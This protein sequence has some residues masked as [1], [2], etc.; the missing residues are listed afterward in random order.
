MF[1]CADKKKVVRTA[2]YRL[3]VIFVLYFVK[4]KLQ[5]TVP[6][7]SKM[8]FTAAMLY[9]TKLGKLQ[10]FSIEQSCQ[11]FDMQS[12]QFSSAAYYKTS[13]TDSVEVL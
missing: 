5:Q 12:T 2:V 11:K 13:D 1:V 8:L 6:C 3:V 9:I 4:A 10:I 7:L